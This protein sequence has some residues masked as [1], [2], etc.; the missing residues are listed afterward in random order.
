MKFNGTLSVNNFV[1]AYLW[2][3]HFESDVGS[4]LGVV[5]WDWLTC[6]YSRNYDEIKQGINACKN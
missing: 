4:W 1:Y 2:G 6:G 3:N 5:S